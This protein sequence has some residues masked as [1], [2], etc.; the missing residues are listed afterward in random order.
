MSYGIRFDNT[1]VH[2]PDTLFAQHEPEPVSEPRLVL[3]NRALADELGLDA[4][5]LAGDQGALLF[6]GNELAEGA[7]PLAQAYAGHQFGHPN[8]L[9]DGRAILLG[10]QLTPDDRRRDLQLKGSGRTPFSRGGDG[11][12]A[13]GPMLREYIISE[14]LHG[15]GI[16]TTRSLA[17]VTTG[18]PV[19][20]ERVLP[21]AILT[22]VAA[23]HLR[24]G[25][26][27]YAASQR[28]PDL[29]Q[30]LVDYTIDRHYPALKGA[31]NPALALLEA[32]SERQMD[33][34]VAWMRVGFIHGV[35]NTDNITLSGESIDYGPCAFMDAYDQ[36]TVF[37]SVDVQGRYAYGN[38]PRIT[39]WNLARFAETLIPMI[40]DDPGTAVGKAE[41]VIHAFPDRYE[42]KWLAMMRRKLGLFGE[43]TEDAAL[44]QDLLS[45][46]ARQGA[47]Y[48]NTFRDLIREAAPDDAIYQDR[49]FREWHERWQA[50]LSRNKKPLASSFCLMRH[51][52]PAVI[53]RNHRVEQALEAATREGDLGPA[54]S[55][56]AALATPY[57]DDGT[58]ADYQQ[59]PAPEEAVTRTFCGT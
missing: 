46:M 16:P 2:L 6:S 45:W 40:D 39:Q 47:D 5:A 13:L 48:T 52:N 29:V 11:R 57:E 38:Q 55:L 43:E 24:V 51:N 14:A 42:E 22:R 20:R 36:H 41:K 56:L 50:R 18:D 28:D 7:Q 31:E 33:L 23:S 12:A 34:V 10:E 35:L 15:L 49:G 44:V 9:G 25:T 19:Y 17:V 30:T 26:F 53:P 4:E 27:Q 32:V 8:M 58:L 3:F 54:Q 1:Y 59:P 37:S 21:G